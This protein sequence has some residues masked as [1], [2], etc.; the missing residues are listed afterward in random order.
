MKAQNLS[1]LADYHNDL[2]ESQYQSSKREPLGTS[3]MRG[4][5]MPDAVQDTEFKY[6]VPTVGSESAKNLVYPHGREKE[7]KP[8][9]TAMYNKT[10][11][12][13]GPGEQKNRNY[14]WPAE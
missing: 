11:G 13:F 7:E 8:D 12:A 10:H 4:H 5:N 2:K 14:V 6:G 3:Y 1:G 9:V